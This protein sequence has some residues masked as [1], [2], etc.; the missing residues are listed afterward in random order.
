MTLVKTAALILHKDLL[1]E[2]QTRARTNALIFFGFSTLL[3]F[4]FALGPDTKLLQRNGA[5]YLWLAL[6]FSVVLALGEA[7]RVESENGAMDGLR[8]APADARAMFLGK[9]LG[10]TLVS[11]LLSWAL[12][13]AMVALYDV[14]LAM[15]PGPLALVLLLGCAAISAPGTVHAAISSN[16]RARDLLLPLMLFPLVVPAL[17]ASVK[18]TGLVL[19]GDPMGQLSG[20]LGLLAGF[21]VTFWG[22]G[23]LLFPKVIEP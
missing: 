8:L 7:F 2:W 6:L 18:A 23:F 12:V 4:S 20:W 21:N 17:L 1:L 16:A 19:A 22:A 3:L 5:G 13:P 9:A 10:T 11:F 14:K 15:G